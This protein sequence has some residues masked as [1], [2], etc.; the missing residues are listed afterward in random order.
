M[1]PA[2]LSLP[3]VPQIVTIGPV[4]FVD[5][6]GRPVQSTHGVAGPGPVFAFDWIASRVAKASIAGSETI[7]SH[8]CDIVVVEYDRSR[9]AVVAGKPVR[10]WID[11]K[12]NLVWRMKYSEPDVFAKPPLINWT[13]VWDEWTED[14]PLSSR[15]LAAASRLPSGEQRKE[16]IGHAAPD[17]KGYTLDGQP[18]QLSKLKGKAV[19]IDLW[20]TWCGVCSEEM[21]FLEHLKTTLA[22][23]N[24]EIWGVTEEPPDSARRWMRE[25]RRTLSS[26]VVE[27]GSA[28]HAYS[29]D[30]VP[31][32]VVI[33]RN[34]IVVDHRT[35]LT[36]E[37]DLRKS[38][39]LALAH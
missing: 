34:G 17:I 24:V 13:V 12:S 1:T 32:L 21:E 5:R 16:F 28:F 14:Q 19:V 29:I 20:A 9:A 15:A 8:E 3:M 7:R 2:E 26:V 36:G 22:N 39:Q 6:R 37:E 38:I 25:R 30:T 18:F 35:G 11:R 4:E 23:P 27:P 33:D 31:Q 10:Y